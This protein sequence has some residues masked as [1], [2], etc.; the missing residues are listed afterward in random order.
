MSFRH[1]ASSCCESHASKRCIPRQKIA[2]FLVWQTQFKKWQ[3][4]KQLPDEK[5][6]LRSLFGIIPVTAR[7]GCL[8]AMGFKALG[9]W[10][11]SYLARW[12][13]PWL[14]SCRRACCYW[15][16]L[17]TGLLLKKAPFFGE[18][19]PKFPWDVPISWGVWGKFLCSLPLS[20]SIGSFPSP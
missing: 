6:S 9:K 20:T 13:S 3:G 19:V 7:W 10:L 4:L 17:L 11:L 18:M 14:W 8:G 16:C 12:V 1:R 15:G 2:P 5:E